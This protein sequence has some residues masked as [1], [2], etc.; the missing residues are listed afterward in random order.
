MLD[1]MSE[2]KNCSRNGARLQ[3]HRKA[4]AP[5]TRS[6]NKQECLTLEKLRKSVTVQQPK[7]PPRRVGTSCVKISEVSLSEIS[8]L[9]TAK[10]FL[11]RTA[12]VTR[13]SE[14][15]ERFK[16]I[17]NEMLMKAG[18]E[19]DWNAPSWST[20]PNSGRARESELVDTARAVRPHLKAKRMVVC[21]TP[22]EMGDPPH[23]GPRVK[24]PSKGLSDAPRRWWCVLCH[25]LP[26]SLVE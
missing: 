11:A 10:T 1:A 3:G 24:K 14:P 15:A 25:P 8:C 19:S 16:H 18:A 9:A 7:Q 26:K 21:Q 17:N 20:S 4:T 23:F 6:Y 5:E 12:E 2:P 22:R 13:D